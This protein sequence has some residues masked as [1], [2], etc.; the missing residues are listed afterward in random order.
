LEGEADVAQ[1]LMSLLAFA[2]LAV[3]LTFARWLGRK[4]PRACGQCD[5]CAR[6]PRSRLNR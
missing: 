2:L 3:A 4:G 6:N 1:F 5:A